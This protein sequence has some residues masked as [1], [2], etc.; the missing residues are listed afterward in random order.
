MVAKSGGQA[1]ECVSWPR[2]CR[3]EFVY[4]QAGPSMLELTEE[5]QRALVI[6]V[7]RTDVKKEEYGAAHQFNWKKVGLS[8]AY[9][10]KELVTFN[11]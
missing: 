11:Y 6:V 10:K 7:L 8:R 5:E 3:G 1:K 4:G 9:Y 2:Y